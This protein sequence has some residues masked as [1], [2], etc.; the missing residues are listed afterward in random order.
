MTDVTSSVGRVFWSI[1]RSVRCFSRLTACRNMVYVRADC[2]VSLPALSMT[3]FS[4]IISGIFIG[5]RRFSVAVIG[6]WGEKWR[7]AGGELIR[8]MILNRAMDPNFS[9]HCPAQFF[10]KILL[11]RVYHIRGREHIEPGPKIKSSTNDGISVH[12]RKYL[13]LRL[14]PQC[15]KQLAGQQRY[16]WLHPNHLLGRENV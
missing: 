14:D 1:S 4:T 11:P 12:A 16:T 5:T 7:P 15:M 10:L 9:A 13:F 6:K 3:W 8:S 2:V